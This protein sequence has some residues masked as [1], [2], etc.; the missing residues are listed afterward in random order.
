[1]EKDVDALIVKFRR[2]TTERADGNLEHA[3]TLFNTIK[4]SDFPA[5]PEFPMSHGVLS[6]WEGALFFIDHDWDDKEWCSKFLA[7]V[8]RV[9]QQA[10]GRS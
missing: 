7:D 1:M 6:D 5:M 3:F 4:V 8:I 10:P 9:L 2:I